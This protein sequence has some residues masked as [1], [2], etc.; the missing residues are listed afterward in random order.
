MNAGIRRRLTTTVVA[1]SVAL[2]LLLAVWVASAGPA[3]EWSPNSGSR[4]RERVQIDTPV[5]TPGEERRCSDHRCDPPDG[6][7]AAI[8]GGL[9]IVVGML[10]I[11]AIIALL[12]SGASRRFR[13][14]RSGALAA[15]GAPLADVAGAVRDDAEHQYAALRGGAPRN[16]IVACWARLEES[17]TTA[18][19]TVRG[20]E[21][22][23]EITRRVLATYVVDDSAINRLAALYREARFSRHEIT[24]S[25]RGEAIEALG[26]LH[27]GLAS[28]TRSGGAS[29]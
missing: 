3:L 2:V 9:F 15:P 7:F 24:E 17:A 26:R 6:P 1:G 20:S 16:A 29:R 11:V 28:P 18:G 27:D 10:L 8:V 5:Q 4:D 12:R 14:R 19:L 23:S 22:S 21:T 13:R 25:M